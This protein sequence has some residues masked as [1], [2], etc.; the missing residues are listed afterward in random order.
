VAEKILGRA[1]GKADARAGE[2][3]EA[4]P[5]LLM[6]HENTYLV[7]KAFREIGAKKLY[8]PDRIAVVLDHRAPANTVETASAHS[9]IRKLVKDLGIKSFFDVGTGICH[10]VLVEEHLAK[11]GQ[12]VVGTDSHTST[13]GAVGAFATGIGATEMAGAWAT[14]Y[15]WLKVPE[16]VRVH[17]RGHL[18]KAVFPKDVS[19]HLASEM[20]PSGAEY[21]CIEFDG[22][23]LFDVSISGRMV[24]CNMAT[25]LGAKS[26]I[27]PADST[28]STW[29]PE[30]CGPLG[31]A[32]KSDQNARFV[33]SID[34]DVGK[35]PPMVSGPDRVEAAAH[36]DKFQGIEVDQAF[37]GTC[38]NGRLE[39]LIAAS[40]V[41]KGNKVAP[42]VRLLVA[43]A[44]RNVL[45][46]AMEMGVIQTI[47]AAGGTILPPGCGPCLGAHG[48]V[49]GPGEVCISSGNRNFKGRMGSGE[50]EVYIASPATV[51]AS[52]I[53]G[54]ITDPRGWLTVDL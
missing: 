39:D 43:P 28:F 10:Q 15:L 3:V 49:M 30:H 7:G 17:M 35:I 6:S 18:E 38:T 26:A 20:G 19:L 22:I 1:A 47:V 23:F 14:G 11:P 21:M 16:T 37:I 12:L 33:E 48:G 52:A 13:A 46:T 40:W 8:D 27:A 9:H 32:C 31:H 2:V 4:Y 34:L 44:S 53:T 42:G 45:S 54:R 5:D 51:A 41:L 36:V 50:A 24:L 29:S 25:E